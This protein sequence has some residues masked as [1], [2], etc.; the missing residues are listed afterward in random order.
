M[1][2]PYR[3]TRSRTTSSRIVRIH[4]RR[5]TIVRG[6]IHTQCNRRRTDRP[7]RQRNS[8][9]ASNPRRHEVRRSTT[10]VRNRRPIRS[11]RPN[12]SNSGRYNSAGR[13]ICIHTHARHGRIIRPG[14]RQRRN[15]ASN[16]P[17]RQNVAGRAF[18][19]R[20]Y[21]GFKRRARGE[22]SRSMGFQI[23]PNPGRISMRR[24]ITARVINGRVN[25]RVTVRNRRHS[26]GHRG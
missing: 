13:N 12:Q 7:T 4:G 11:L 15:S 8:S 9:G 17:C 18:A 23:T 16:Y 3:T 25:T 2:R 22:R 20:N 1:N 5:R 24:R 21:H 26:N 6:R 14:S 10:L 19:Q